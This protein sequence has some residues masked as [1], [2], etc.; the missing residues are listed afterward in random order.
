MHTCSRRSLL[1]HWCLLC[2]LKT[3]FFF[4]SLVYE[5]IENGKILAD[6]RRTLKSSSHYVLEKD[7]WSGED[8]WV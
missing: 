6:P 4:F 2:E 8:R 7:L 3:F 1:Q 5:R